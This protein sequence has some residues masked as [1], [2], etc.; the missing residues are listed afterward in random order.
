[1]THSDKCLGEDLHDIHHNYN[2][3]N[4]SPFVLEKGPTTVP[5]HF[6]SNKHTQN[7]LTVQIPQFIALDP[8]DVF[9]NDFRETREHWFIHCLRTL[10][11]LGLNTID[12]K[13]HRQ[14]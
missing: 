7:D 3:Q 13:K 1:M 11:P 4:A 10:K 14:R 9:M 5:R 8:S 6:G 12:E 2:T